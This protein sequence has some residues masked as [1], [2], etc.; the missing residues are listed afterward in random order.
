MK[1]EGK[2]LTF[3][4]IKTK[5]VINNSITTI[6]RLKNEQ[7]CSTTTVW[8]CVFDIVCSKYIQ[9]NHVNST[10]FAID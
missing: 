2:K 10:E 3:Y 8:C 7:K 5:H 9:Q 1:F 4:R 6:L